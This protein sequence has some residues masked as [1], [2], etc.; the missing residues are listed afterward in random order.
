MNIKVTVKNE[1]D[2]DKVKTS[3]NVLVMGKP[4]NTTKGSVGIPS[5]ESRS[6]YIHAN[7]YLV[8]EV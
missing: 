2:P 3:V 5:G 1:E 4:E 7:Q 6:F 8:V